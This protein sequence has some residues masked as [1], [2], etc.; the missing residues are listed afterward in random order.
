MVFKRDAWMGGLA[1][2]TWRFPYDL[3][4]MTGMDSKGMTVWAGFKISW[5]STAKK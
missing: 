5:M 4:E 1:R 3:V 2:H